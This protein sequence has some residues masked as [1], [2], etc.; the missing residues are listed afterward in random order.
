MGHHAC[1]RSSEG[2]PASPKRVARLMREDGLVAR[3]RKRHR[4]TT[5]DSNHDHPIAPNLLARQ[6]DAM[7]WS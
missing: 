1:I 4:I 5:T 7:R 2:L 6:F 3:P